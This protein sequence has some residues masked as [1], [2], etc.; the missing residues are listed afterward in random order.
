[1][2]KLPHAMLGPEHL[3]QGVTSPESYR[4]AFERHCA[5]G[6]RR[7]P[8]LI[9]PR[10][11]RSVAAVQP[12]V[13]DGS[14]KVACASK[15]CGEHPLVSFPWGGLA[16]CFAC[17]ATYEG[18][19][20]PADRSEIERLLLMRPDLRTRNWLPGETVADLARENAEH[21]IREAA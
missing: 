15:D 3:I 13:A 9:W 16:I 7:F 14:W 17:G 21:D 19:P 5:E 10:S 2:P 6:R 20:S 11:W 4:L 1:M 12:F 18:V 8:N